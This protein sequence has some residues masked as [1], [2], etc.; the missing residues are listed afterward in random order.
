VSICPNEDELLAL[1]EGAIPPGDA[2]RVTSHIESCDACHVLVAHARQTL[3]GRSGSLASSGAAQRTQEQPAG[4]LA[5]GTR[6]GRYVILELVGAGAMGTV[7]SAYD[8]ELDRRIAIKLFRADSKAGGLGPE[9][10]QARLLREAQ[11]MARLS[12]PNVVAVHDVGAYQGGVFVAMDFIAG[13]TLRAWLTERARSLPEVVAALTEA[14]RGLAAAHRSGI[15]HR[16]F[17][18]DNVLVDRE[19]RIY[20][21]DF[22]LARLQGEPPARPDSAAAHEPA[23]APLLTGNVA[24]T[25]AYM[26]P[27]QWAGAAVDERA[28]VFAYCVTLYEAIYGARPYP[29]EDP[30][31]YRAALERDSLPPPPKGINVPV[32][33]RNVLTRGLLAHPEDRFPSMEA[34]LAE[35]SRN[36]AAKRRFAIRASV[37]LGCVVA[38]LLGARALDRRSALV[39]AAGEP[40]LAGVWD[41]ARREAVR[42]AFLAT[43]QANAAGA[44][45]NTSRALDEFAT[46]W[47]GSH[48]E[49]CEAT[50][51]RHEQ[52]EDMLDLRM[53]CLDERLSQARALTDLFTHADAP[54]LVKSAG[55]ARSLES[56]ATCT[57]AWLL[58]TTGRLPDTPEAR[59]RSAAVEAKIARAKALEYAGRFKDVG[60]AA[61]EALDA[62]E[63]EGFRPLAAEASYWLGVSESRLGH[64]DK[65]ETLF[66]N[67]AT[68]AQAAA[69]DDLAALAFA[70]VAQDLAHEKRFKEAYLVLDLSRAAIERLGGRDDLEANRLRRFASALTS[71]GRA[72]EAIPAYRQALVL[73]ERVSGP[74]SFAVAG[75]YTAMARSLTADAKQQ[76]GLE[77]VQ[78]GE[79]IYLKLFG[80]DYPLV[81]EALLQEG[82]I[83]RQLERK[84]EAVSTLKRALA[85]RLKVYGPNHPSIPEAMF[86]LGHALTW[87]GRPA[88]AV[89]ILERG[90]ETGDRINTP[91]EDVPECLAGLGEAYFAMGQAARAVEYYE[92]ALA[93]PKAAALGATTAWVKMGMAKALWGAG[94]KAR[95]I[96][97]AQQ[98]RAMYASA[99]SGMNTSTE[100]AELDKWL[101]ERGYAPPAPSPKGTSPK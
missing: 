93:H 50:R 43:G 73:Q 23:P 30:A 49:T 57:A 83:L 91:Y 13:P 22:G 67:A 92:K 101:K 78:H 58:R 54:L 31:A 15:V 27:E 63:H 96:T 55:A 80:P 20:V 61:K 70:Y 84:E 28:D 37:V 62:A 34:L 1:A 88:E 16:D 25:P 48:R 46:A 95:A 24:G 98:S 17:K 14:G 85:A 65:S 40:R 45:E 60:A 76:E 4:P 33:V 87:V 5:A 79:S 2:L 72:K 47:L 36:P 97:T 35:L 66:V 51:L 18:P 3:L 82:H 11:A 10:L 39:C 8:P 32:H 75:L 71:E 38:L 94:Q 53:A 89:P 7:Y 41:P 19:G 12:H 42:A 90:V 21:T 64:V 74:D 68:R 81:A 99:S 26:A 100:L 44:F 52:S 69:R 86:F 29:S 59:A 9:V 6:V 56:P 77:A